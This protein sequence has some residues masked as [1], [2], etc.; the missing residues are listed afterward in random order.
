MQKR[1]TGDVADDDNDNIYNNAGGDNLAVNNNPGP[2]GDA[3]YNI[4]GKEMLATMMIHEVA[5]RD[6]DDTDDDDND[7]DDDDNDDTDDDQITHAA[8]LSLLRWG[9]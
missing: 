2:Y 5:A 9:G 3:D 4:D 7:S 1:G 8:G 6:E